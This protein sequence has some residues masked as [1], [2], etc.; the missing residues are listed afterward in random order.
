MWEGLRDD[1]WVEDA[2]VV[3]NPKILLRAALRRAGKETK[4]ADLS[5]DESIAARAE[6][7]CLYWAKIAAATQDVRSFRRRFLGGG[8]ISTSSASD[9]IL[10]PAASIWRLETFRRKGIP[11]IGHKSEI[12]SKGKLKV[13][14]PEGAV[15]VA[16]KQQHRLTVLRM[17]DGEA[18][19]PMT[20]LRGSVIEELHNV[21]TTLARRF[22]WEAPYAAWFI[23]TGQ[24]PWVP[25]LKADVEG[26]DDL[27][28]GSI[29]ITAAHWVP[30]EAVCKFYAELKS[31]LNPS[32]TPSL[33]RLALFRFFVEN[34]SGT[35]SINKIG[36]HIGLQAPDINNIGSHIGLQS[37]A[38]WRQMME[39]W[40]EEHPDWHYANV[41]NFHRD[42]QAAF[43]SLAHPSF[44]IP[45][46]VTYVQQ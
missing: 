26:P 4:E 25:P 1:G 43:K 21:A 11:V 41:R 17:W 18:E 5:A 32:P 23:L 31:G 34:S 36:S 38:N 7:L 16:F 35:L 2:I 19:W 9:L 42:F 10:S 44:S 28:H 3:G 15:E 33:R 6:A 8:T 13:T 22:P 20:V 12:L 46:G 40:N 27:N 37:P 29:T 30:K 24:S 14:W 45:P 39:R